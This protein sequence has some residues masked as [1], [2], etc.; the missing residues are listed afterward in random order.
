[1][2]EKPPS[3]GAGALLLALIACIGLGVLLFVGLLLLDLDGESSG[4]SAGKQV[5]NCFTMTESLCEAIGRYN[6]SSG[7]CC[8]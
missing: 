6:Q 7:Q 1:M 4:P 3:D 2:T 5:G 8:L